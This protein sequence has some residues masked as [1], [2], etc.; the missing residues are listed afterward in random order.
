MG[1]EYFTFLCAFIILA[2]A[3]IGTVPFCLSNIFKYVAYKFSKY[4]I[5]WRHYKEMGKDKWAWIIES[6]EV[7][8]DMQELEQWTQNIWDR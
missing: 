7:A 3:T 4:V 6:H 8:L 2:Y 1:E 5:A